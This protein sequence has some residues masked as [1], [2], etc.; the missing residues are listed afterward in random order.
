MNSTIV[1]LRLALG[2]VATVF[3]VGMLG[4]WSLGLSPLD[5]AYQTVTTV[6]TVTTVGFRGLAVFGTDE[7]WFTMVLIVLG[8]STVLHTLTLAVQVVVEG[9]LREFVGGD[10]WIAN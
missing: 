9:Q 10:A 5:V 6:T 8:V 4:Y 3:L 7:K 2:M 1:R